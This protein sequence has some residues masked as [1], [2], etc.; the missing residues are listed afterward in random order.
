[1][2]PQVIPS[3]DLRVYSQF[4]KKILPKERSF[5]AVRLEN[6]TTDGSLATVPSRDSSVSPLTGKGQSTG[7]KPCGRLRN[8]PCRSRIIARLDI[9]SME[10]LPRPLAKSQIQKGPWPACLATVI[11]STIF[12]LAVTTAISSS[13][14]QSGTT[15]TMLFSVKSWC[16]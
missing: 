5:G 14:L 8:K 4:F 10:A 12:W 13:D 16:R 9:R 15:L 1:M 6:V 3:Q 7:C 2:T 11:S